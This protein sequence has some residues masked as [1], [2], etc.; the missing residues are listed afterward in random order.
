MIG[1]PFALYTLFSTS[2]SQDPISSARA[3]NQI[4]SFFSWSLLV[5][6]F[7]PSLSIQIRRLNDIGK[8]PA[9]VLLSFVPFISLILLFWYAKPSKSWQNTLNTKKKKTKITPKNELGDLFDMEERLA[10]LKNMVDRGIISNK[11]YKNLRKKA[12][13]L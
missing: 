4:T 1:I 13:G 12:L 3:V 11:E 9:W 6:S 8:E 2:N 7:I 10:N 5:I